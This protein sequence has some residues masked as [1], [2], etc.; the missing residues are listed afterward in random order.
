MRVERA[1]HDASSIA[2][3]L[4]TDALTWKA[5][6]H[7]S[8]FGTSR[9]RIPTVASSESR[10]ESIRRQASAASGGHG[11]FLQSRIASSISND[12]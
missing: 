11:L 6:I 10:C 12:R 8:Q 9:V 3:T 5:G 4:H 1:K 2:R 7:R